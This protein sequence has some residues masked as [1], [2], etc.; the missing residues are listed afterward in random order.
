[1]MH[2]AAATSVCY[3]I[4]FVVVVVVA[5]L[6]IYVEFPAQFAASMTLLVPYFHLLFCSGRK[7]L[8]L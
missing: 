1:M 7:Q 4:S 6:G 5:V 3:G 2:L 8:C